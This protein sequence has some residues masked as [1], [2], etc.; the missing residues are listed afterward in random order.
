MLAASI[1]MMVSCAAM[2]LY[3]RVLAIVAKPVR[4]GRLGSFRKLYLIQNGEML[5]P[6]STGIRRSR[7]TIVEVKPN[8]TLN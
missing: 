1:V 7:R 4:L 6:R 5:I 2:A 8:T 3:A